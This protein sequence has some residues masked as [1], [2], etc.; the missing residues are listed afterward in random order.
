M[1]H[2]HFLFEGEAHYGVVEHRADE[3]WIVDLAPAPEEI[4]DEIDPTEGLTIDCR[5]LQCNSSAWQESL[6]E[7][8]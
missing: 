5:S 4:S 6:E 2:C 1:K 3:R 7:V 8:H